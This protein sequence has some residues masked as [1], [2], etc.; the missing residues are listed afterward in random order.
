ME[1]QSSP[2]HCWK[3]G[4]TEWKRV[5]RVGKEMFLLLRVHGLLSVGHSS[6]LSGYWEAEAKRPQIRSP[7][8][9]SW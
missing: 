4:G 1:L 3:C 2:Q 8:S 9:Q 5:E 6:D 7:Q